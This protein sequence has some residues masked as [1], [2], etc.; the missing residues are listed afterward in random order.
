MIVIMTGDGDSPE[1]AAKELNKKIRELENDGKVK[2]LWKPKQTVEHD[3]GEK[4]YYLT[5]QFKVKTK[6]KSEE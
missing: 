6:K 1:S 4:W 3:N 5:Q 2:P